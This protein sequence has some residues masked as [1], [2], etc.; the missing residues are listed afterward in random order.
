[1]YKLIFLIFNF[2]TACFLIGCSNYDNDYFIYV[3]NKASNSLKDFI[4]HNDKIRIILSADYIND[5]KNLDDTPEYFIISK[6]DLGYHIIDTGLNPKYNQKPTIIAILYPYTTTTQETRTITECDNVTIPEYDS[7]TNSFQ[8]TT[9]QMCSDK[10]ITVD[11]YHYFYNL[12]FY[13][14]KDLNNPLLD[15]QKKLKHYDF[16]IAPKIINNAPIIF[17]SKI[18]NALNTESNSESNFIILTNA[19]T[20]T[21]PLNKNVNVYFNYFSPTFTPTYLSIN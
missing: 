12:G 7:S 1:M 21:F 13:R 5:T 18:N 10:E 20:E 17:S 9:Q 3:Q 11:I 14:S 4:H 15:C 2:I 16:C 6:N 8:N 19:I